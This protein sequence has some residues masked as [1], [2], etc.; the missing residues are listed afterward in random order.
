MEVALNCTVALGAAGAGH[1]SVVGALGRVDVNGGAFQRAALLGQPM[2]GF[3]V[4]VVYHSD[5]RAGVARLGLARRHVDIIDESLFLAHGC[6]DDERG[7]LT[8][9]KLAGGGRR[10]LRG[11]PRWGR[12]L[13]PVEHDGDAALVVHNLPRG[14]LIV[15]LQSVNRLAHDL[16]NR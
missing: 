16:W 1:M 15:Q 13:V 9:R 6:L 10:R 2:N 7:P 4:V 12:T 3:N 8:R 5:L 11:G 14:R